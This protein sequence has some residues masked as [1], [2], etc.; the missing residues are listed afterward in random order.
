MIKSAKIYSYQYFSSAFPRE[1]AT[2]QEKSLQTCPHESSASVASSGLDYTFLLYA[3]KPLSFI[4]SGAS[5][6]RNV[7]GL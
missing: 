3:L 7:P 2:V 4:M 6:L 5:H 1:K